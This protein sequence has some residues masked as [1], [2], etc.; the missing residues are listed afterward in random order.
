MQKASFSKTLKKKRQT[1][2]MHSSLFNNRKEV[3][4]TPTLEKKKSHVV[5]VLCSL[6]ILSGLNSVSTMQVETTKRFQ[7]L[8]FPLKC[9]VNFEWHK[10][11]EHW[12]LVRTWL[13]KGKQRSWPWKITL[14]L[15][16]GMSNKSKTHLAV[17]RQ[18]ETIQTVYL[19]LPNLEEITDWVGLL[20]INRNTSTW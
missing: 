3:F 1:S 6:H 4:H 16:S 10:T 14:Y 19:N 18:N 15:I 5:P 13:E 12:G 2:L 8:T 20:Q 7:T 9:V 11:V 17:L